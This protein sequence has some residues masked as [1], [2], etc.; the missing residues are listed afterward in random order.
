MSPLIEARGLCSGYTQVPVVRELDIEVRH[1]EV[2]GLLGANGAGKTTTLLTL[3]GELTP[4]AGAVKWKG[5][6]CDAP[7][8]RRAR[9]GLGYIT[10]ERSVFSGLTTA[11]NIRVGDCDVSAVLEIFPELEPR[12]GVKA[13][14]LSGGEQQML[15]LG[16][17]LARKPALLLADELSQGL[18]P[19]VVRRLLRAVRAAADGGMGV[20][21]VEQHVSQALKVCD[22]AYLMR[23]GKVELSGTTDELQTR[24]AEIQAA[25]LSGPGR[26][27][28]S[29]QG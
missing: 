11:E 1:G 27:D 16:R 5:E 25:Y 14:M 29:P 21:L 24:M 19:L 17:V 20:L 18:A 7:L 6:V 8:F 3:A 2:V 23:R 26:S 9:T 15:S 10:E 12:L 4:T 22:R 13:G 28:D